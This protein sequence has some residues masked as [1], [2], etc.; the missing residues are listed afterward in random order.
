MKITVCRNEVDN[1]KIFKLLERPLESAYKAGVLAGAWKTLDKD[2]SL[3][4][5]FTRNKMLELNKGEPIWARYKL[6][7]LKESETSGQ[8]TTTLD[9]CCTQANLVSRYGDDPLY[10]IATR[11]FVD[12]RKFA[13]YDKYGLNADV[14][15]LTLAFVVELGVAIE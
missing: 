11:L 14:R 9:Y 10:R 8:D 2:S 5:L 6:R 12:E 13:Y 7:M 1:A 3:F 4:Q 15:R